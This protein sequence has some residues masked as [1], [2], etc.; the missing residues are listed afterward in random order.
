[1]KDEQQDL[2]IPL[3]L[4]MKCKGK[5]DRPSH[6]DYRLTDEYVERGRTEERIE[7][8]TGATWKPT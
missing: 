5:S 6:G 1:M 8:G 3:V 4:F 2:P 7:E